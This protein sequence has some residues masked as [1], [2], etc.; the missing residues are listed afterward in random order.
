MRDRFGRNID[1]LRLSVTDL[2]NLRCRYCMPEQ[3]ICKKEHAD[4][5]TEEEMLCAAQAAVS[6][7]I[8]KIRITGGEPLV[9]KNIL[10]ICEKIGNIPGVE[11]LCLTTN[12]ILLPKMARELKMAGVSGVNISLDTLIEERYKF[13]TRR[14]TLR[15]ALDG[16]EAALNTGFGKV[17]INVV[18]LGGFNDD[19]ILPLAELTRKYPVDVRFIEWMP[20]YDSGDFD[21]E[22]IYPCHRAFERIREREKELIPQEA[23]GGVAKLYRMPGAMGNVGFITPISA[24]FCKECRRI[25]VTSDGKIKPCLHS[26]EEWPVKGM[27]REGMKEQMKRAIWAKPECHAGM[28]AECRSQSGRNM[29]RIGG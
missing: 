1:Y 9:K 18:L 19:E 28:S 25:R 27:S 22:A 6:L 11:E 23:D 17:K 5:M 2:C 3:G 20:M 14:G 21:G 8:H 10:S 7:G 16:L 26:R 4:M 12:G 29:N 13:I 15:Q 24:H